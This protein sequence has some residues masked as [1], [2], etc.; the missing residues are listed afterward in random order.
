MTIMN[1][2][3]AQLR[4]A[5]QAGD[6]TVQEV[7]AA[8]FERLEKV[9]PQIQ[10][11]ITVTKEEAMKRAEEL[12]A[13][14]ASARGPLF[15]LPIAVKDNIVTKGIKT[16]CASRMLEN[17]IPV[18]DATVMNKLAEAGAVM[19][20]KVNMDE[21]AM[22][23]MTAT[24][25]FFETKNP[26]DLTKVPG[27]SSGGSAAAV[28]AGIVPFAL[29]SDTGGSIRQPAAF[30]GI[31]GMK[32]TYGRISRLGLVAFAS[33][34]DQM[35]PMTRT[36]EDNAMLL[37]AIAGEDMYDASSAAE[38]VPNFSEKIG[39]SIEGLKVAVPKEFLGEGV[40]ADVKA[41]VEAAIEQLKELGAIVEEVSLPH[42]KYASEVYYVI[43]SAEASSNFSRYDGIRYGHRAEGVE[44]LYDLYRQSRKE[45]FGEEVKKRLLFGTYAL[46][47]KHHE[48]L[49]VQAQKVRRLIAE[50]LASV[51]ES[52][53]VIVGPTAA[54]TAYG[55]DEK[56]EG[57]TA[58]MNDVLTIPANLAGLP[59]MSV[60]CGLA[61]GLP[62][63]L[64][65]IGKHFDEATLYQVAAAYEEKM[66]LYEQLQA[67]S[68]GANA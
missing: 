27:G 21:F 63:G 48:P 38:D 16:T 62:V 23:S 40:A 55:L 50:E 29:G 9:D 52:Y 57:L 31:V 59:A 17:F 33:S 10:A 54:T 53:D 34:L 1:Q 56:Q 12:D 11:F 43:A 51:F 4:Q 25:Y 5:L 15:G 19:I 6:V 28:A 14:D 46:S 24:S 26:W 68:G 67:L 32:P 8:S 2:T 20:G 22:G 30:C 58:Y 35:G 44:N 45:G 49:Y 3:A 13:L 61:E 18:Y 64:Q 41:S 65:L 36:V 60:P 47:A 42:A 39:H 7:V 66:S 37:Q